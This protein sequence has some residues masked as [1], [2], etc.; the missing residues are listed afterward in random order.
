ML[1][2]RCASLAHANKTELRAAVQVWIDNQGKL[3]DGLV[4]LPGDAGLQAAADAVETP[5][6][7]PN[8]R[9]LVSTYELKSEA[10][11]LTY[12]SKDFSLDTG[13]V[14]SVLRRLSRRAGGFFEAPRADK[15]A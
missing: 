1:A 5:P 10:F 9:V 12:K 6:F 7:V 13:D 14:G 15:N 8:H 2:R 11:M 3:P 4:L